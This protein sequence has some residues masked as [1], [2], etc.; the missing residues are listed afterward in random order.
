MKKEIGLIEEFDKAT[1]IARET[2][3]DNEGLFM[4]VAIPKIKKDEFEKWQ[5]GESLKLV[6][7]MCSSCT[8]RE[9]TVYFNLLSHARDRLIKREPMVLMGDYISRIKSRLVIDEEDLKDE[10]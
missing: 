1:K 5:L 7:V 4:V 2:I 6:D 3:K 10:S 9:L 8:G